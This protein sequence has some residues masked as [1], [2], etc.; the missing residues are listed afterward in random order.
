MRIQYRVREDVIEVVRCFGT[1]GEISLPGQIEGIPVRK[2]APYAFLP[3]RK[4]KTGMC[5]PL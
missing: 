2:V 1:D 4:K 3:E 5:I